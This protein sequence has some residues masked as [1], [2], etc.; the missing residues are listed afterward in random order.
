M[1]T[2]RLLFLSC[3]YLEMECTDILKRLSPIWAQMR[4]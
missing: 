3:K 1:E 4:I 2:S